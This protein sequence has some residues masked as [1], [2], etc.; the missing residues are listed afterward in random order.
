MLKMLIILLKT[1]LKTYK[2]F[3]D[4]FGSH[5]G[6]QWLPSLHTILLG[7]GGTIYN[8]HT[9]ESFKEL[10]LDSQRVNNFASKF[11]VHYVNYA[12]KLVH[13]KCALSSNVINSHQVKPAT[14]LI[15]IDFPPFLM[16]EE[17]YGTRYQS[18]SF[19]LI[20][21]E[22]VCSLPAWLFC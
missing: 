17:F 9:L 12:A 1:A 10:G 8:N 2:I 13:T 16:G 4:I 19:S 14:L 6:F 11:H 15:P 5:V 18:G 21:V 3:C 7:V 20:I 22:S